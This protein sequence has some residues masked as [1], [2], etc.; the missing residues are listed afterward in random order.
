MKKLLS[1]SSFLLILSLVSSLNAA[2]ISADWR[3]VSDGL[4][5]QDTSTG[6]EWLDMTAS[7]NIA[8]ESIINNSGAG[9]ALTSDGWNL[10]NN[11]QVEQL[12]INAGIPIG[13]NTPNGYAGAMLL[14]GL[15]GQTYPYADIQAF[16][17]NIAPTP[18]ESFGTYLSTPNVLAFNG[19][20]GSDFNGAAPIGL[21]VPFIGNWLVR[22]TAAPVPEPA[23]LLLLGTG[24]IGL[25]GY[26]RKK[27][28]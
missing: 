21:S 14:I 4:I 22:E 10:A 6:L 7:V 2:L 15:M 1:T 25:A 18:P 3:A 8:P 13:A 5:T 12:F 27:L 11:A 16:S 20:G 9:A 28:S 19:G 23:T 17:S 24:L 26:G